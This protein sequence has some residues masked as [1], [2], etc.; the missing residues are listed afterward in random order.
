MLFLTSLFDELLIV[1][2]L[3]LAVEGHFLPCWQVFLRCPV[4]EIIQCPFA[5][6]FM[7]V[8]REGNVQERSGRLGRN[9][10]TQSVMRLRVVFS[11][12]YFPRLSAPA[13]DG[14]GEELKLPARA[15][16]WGI[17]PR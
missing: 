6:D 12:V 1:N 3:A 15:V 4:P 5:V 16:V 10:S 8:N 9:L 13:Q 14:E 7:Y 2:N 17:L 11:V